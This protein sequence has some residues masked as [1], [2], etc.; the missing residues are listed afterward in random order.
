MGLL[1]AAMLL[2]AWFL[3][4]CTGEDPQIKAIKDRGVLRVGSKVDVPRFGYLNP[5]TGQME[6]MEVDI[7]RL[8]AKEI[9][10]DENA[11]AFTSITAQTRGPLLD[12]GEI[13]MVIATFT[14]TEERKQ[15]FNFSRPYYTDMLGYLVRDGEQIKTPMDLNGKTVG[16]AQ[17]STAEATFAEESGKLGIQVTLR[18]FSS[19]PEIQ[20]ALAAGD[21]A[22]FVADKSILYGYLGEGFTL[23]DDGFNPQ[24]YGIGTKLANK[25]LAERVDALM[26][27]FEKNGELEAVH[28]KWGL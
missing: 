4:G 27:Q 26:E 5:E 8:I 13:D 16:V 24:Q 21:V 28:A 2:P 9:L 12:N 6:G 17:G 1:L 14:I 10:G 22:A 15:S 23:L 19:Y 3:T 25:K 11:V 18:G 7:A 20:A